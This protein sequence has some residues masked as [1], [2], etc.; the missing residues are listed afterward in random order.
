MWYAIAGLAVLLVALLVLLWIHYRKAAPT[1]TLF[2]Q[3]AI[4]VDGVLLQKG[5]AIMNATATVDSTIAIQFQLTDKF[6][7]AVGQPTTAPAWTID[8]STLADITVDNTGLNATLTESGKLGVVNITASYAGVT[9]TSA[10][11]LTAGAPTAAELVVTVTPPVAAAPA[12]A[13]PAAQ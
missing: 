5:H 8:D 3:L 1:I 10:I 2:P 9:A 13:A 11:T 6:G 12:P 4:Y 7:N